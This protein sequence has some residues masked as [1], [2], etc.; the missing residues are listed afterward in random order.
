MSLTQQPA[1]RLLRP[2][3]I[4]L[5]VFLAACSDKPEQDTSGMK[6]PVT[7]I[8]VEPQKT[9][10]NVQLPGRVS[11]IEDAEI[12][13][14]VT[15][16][17]KSIEFEQG[18]QVKAGDLLFTIDPA[19]YQAVRDQA[20]AQLQNAQAA[21]KTASS[22]SNRYSKLIDKHAISQ[23]D[24]D[25][26]MAQSR[27]AKAAVAAAKASL[28][29]AE[30]DL[31]YTK[32]TSP[33][34]GTIGK[35]LVTVGALVSASQATNLATVHRF[36]EVYVDITRPVEQL[37]ELR[38]ELREGILKPDADGDTKANILM[39][40]GSIYGHSGK[41]LFSGIAV[42]PTTG[43]VNLRAIFPNPEQEL[44]PGLYVRVQLPQ[45]V[46]EKALIVPAQAIQRTPDGNSTIV[47]IKD[48]K[49]VFTPVQ[50]GAESGQGYIIN[51]GLEA[52]DVV[53]TAGFQKIRPGAPVQA[54][55]PKAEEQ[56][57]A[58]KQ[59]GEAAA[60]DAPQDQNDADQK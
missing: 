34:D 9:Q 56:P 48:D 35:S 20:E 24:Y 40:D 46:D 12:R 17:V 37:A 31:G 22:L 27:Q 33:I 51:D 39:D 2:L 15:G 36:D 50:V 30:I 54:L 49:A 5:L 59:Q 58:D 18:S 41:L 14:R 28:E 13:A 29:S 19:P 53:V 23:Q 8:T 38:K 45:G 21:E 3:A 4:V 60:Q 10:V 42:D 25:N 44:L 52:G 47:L 1:G 7:A 32:V 16:I 26:A 43:Q 55:P 57:G 6:I 11:A